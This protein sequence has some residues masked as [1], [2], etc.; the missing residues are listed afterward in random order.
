M[1][2]G[3]LS[4]GIDWLYPLRVISVF[5]A[6]LWFARVYA[7]LDW[8]WS[9]TAVALGIAA[10]AVW[11]ALEPWAAP[12]SNSGSS[13]QGLASM[14]PVAAAAWLVFRV[15]GSVLAAPLAEEL[16]F[17]GYLMRRLVS[18]DFTTVSPARFSWLALVVSSGLFGAL[19]P[20]RW[21][22]G[23]LAGVLFGLAFARR[24]NVLD[25]V[26]AHA[27][28]NLLIAITVLSTGWWSLW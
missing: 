18:A 26:L 28:A 10:F 19:H 12:S 6:I 25:T 1:V 22:A 13:A 2:T 11:I 23:T 21:L 3:A 4:S 24:G 15:L 17:R 16:A 9:W 27:T 14:T 8:S 20:G 7:T 5:V